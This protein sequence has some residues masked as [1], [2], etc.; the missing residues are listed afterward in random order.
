M[1]NINLTEDEMDAT[2]AH[3]QASKNLNKA[4]KQLSEK[5]ARDGENKY[6]TK[7]FERIFFDALTEVKDGTFK[8]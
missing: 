5:I 7:S 2:D 6:G 3:I 1:P 4:I 8:P